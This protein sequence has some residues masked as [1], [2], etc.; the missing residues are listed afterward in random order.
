M[1]N[2]LRS[3]TVLTSSNITTKLVVMQD[4][5]PISVDT[6]K[7]SL[8]VEQ[9][10]SGIYITLPYNVA[11]RKQC[12][13]TQLPTHLAE[14]L[15]I[16]DA[17]GERQIYRIL[18]ELE[19]GTDD[20]LVAEE[21]SEVSW[22]EKTSRLAL[23]TEA[24]PPEVQTP[25][26][27]QSEA[28]AQRE[29]PVQ[30]GQRIRAST[31]YSRDYRETREVESIIHVAESVSASNARAPAPTFRT[32]PAIIDHEVEAPEYWK[33]LDFVC[34]QARRFANTY[35]NITSATPD[36]LAQ[37]FESLTIHNTDVD[38]ANSPHL[39]GNDVWLS[40]FRVGAAGELL[41]SSN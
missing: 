11:E 22:L 34:K 16:Y 31:T 8:I 10:S 36:D 20:I 1:H 3:A 15:Q 24:Q 30:V 2:N 17:R 40:K 29:I 26:P 14:L 37:L 21:I 39:F 7:S 6:A 32:L 27:Q 18:N 41:V 25:G 13:R 28:Q 33:V 35:Q 19:L 12:M 5:T 23:P 9:K 38:P 4:T